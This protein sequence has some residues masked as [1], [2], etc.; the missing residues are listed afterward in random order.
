MKFNKKIAASL[1]MLAMVGQLGMTS[2]AEDEDGPMTSDNPLAWGLVSFPLRAV[3]GV[4]GLGAGALVGGVKGI[5][6]TEKKF[7]ENTFGEAD[8]NPLLVPVGLIGTAVAIPVGFLSGF[9]EQ[10]V[11]SGQEGFQW[12]DRF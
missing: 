11:K 9:P 5:I 8:E 2:Y 10:A 12:W 3:T 7:A 6:E 1:L 4:V